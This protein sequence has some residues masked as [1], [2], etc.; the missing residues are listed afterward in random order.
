[1]CRMLLTESIVRIDNYRR[2]NE[3]RNRRYGGNK[4]LRHKRATYELM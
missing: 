4:V 2:A 1:M 3:E